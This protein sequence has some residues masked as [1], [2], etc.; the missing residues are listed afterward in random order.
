M[1]NTFLEDDVPGMENPLGLRVEDP[2]SVMPEVT[3][4]NALD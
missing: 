3:D 4:Q 1:P 2:V